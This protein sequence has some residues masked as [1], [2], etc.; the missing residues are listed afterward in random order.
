MKQMRKMK[1]KRLMTAVLL[2][3]MIVSGGRQSYAAEENGESVA[4]SGQMVKPSNLNTEGYDVVLLA[5]NSG[6]VWSQQGE[7][8]KALRGIANLAVGSDIRIGAVYFGETTYK[9]LGLTSMEEK[10]SSTKVLDFLNLTEKNENNRGTN[11]GNALEE[12]QTLFED[13]NANRQRI[14]ILFSD[15]INENLAQSSSFKEAADGK[16]REQAQSLEQKQIPIY[17]VYLQKN[18]DDEDYLKQLVN[19]FNEDN[20]YADERFKKVTDDQ[21]DILSE[22]FAQ[23][24]YSMQNDMKYR[25]IS[26]DSSGT[27]NFYIPEL[28]VRRMQIYLKNDKAYEV[29]LSGPSED[30]GEAQTWGDNGNVYITVDEP[31]TGDWT[32]EITGDGADTVTGTLACYTNISA[33]ASISGDVDENGNIYRNRP[34]KINV[35]FYDEDGSE[36]QPDESAVVSGTLT[37]QNNDGENITQDVEFSSTENGY[38]SAGFQLEDYGTYSYQV[39]LSYA[40]FINLRYDFEGGTVQGMAPLVYNQEG[41]FEGRETEDGEAFTFDTAD[42]YSDPDG[43]KITITGVTQLNEENPVISFEEKDGFLTVTAQDTGEVNFVINIEDESGNTAQIEI[44]GEVIDVVTARI[45]EGLSIFLIVLILAV[46]VGLLIHRNIMKKKVEEERNKMQKAFDSLDDYV[47]STDN[48]TKLRGE[49]NSNL[50]NLYRNIHELLEEKIDGEQLEHFEVR[51]DDLKDLSEKYPDI[52]NSRYEDVTDKLSACRE[53]Q[54]EAE[55]KTSKKPSQKN[56]RLII[57]YM[58]KFSDKTAKFNS[59]VQEYSNVQKKISERADFFADRYMDILD[60]LETSIK[61]NII[62]KWDR[63]I[64]SKECRHVKDHITGY[65]RLDDVGMLDKNGTV[66]LRNLMNERTGIYVYGCQDSEGE[67]ALRICSKDGFYFKNTADGK[68]E[69][70]VKE[71]VLM[72]GENYRIKINDYMGFIRIQVK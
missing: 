41:T 62:V 57:A 52:L 9:K 30:S 48:I 66:S 44:K 6:S 71:A 37:L 25:E 58:V 49:I 69:T 17:C 34:E 33:V 45:I 11:I 53:L 64:G 50:N 18:R 7:R 8:D 12:A 23:T 28:G 26:I 4:T 21:I 27:M 35:S 36:F 19:Y 16:T 10:D 47:N 70:K 43:E 46:I 31:E 15:G 65:Y 39:S 13:Q 29:L 42:L 68:E 54:S 60:M 67:D 1:W 63:Y 14:I 56:L 59:A 5:D 40:D 2:V 22:Q 24:F 72:K 3:V 51:E 55:R 20:D 61:C 38:E 32:L